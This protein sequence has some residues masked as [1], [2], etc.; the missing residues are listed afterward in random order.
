MV[1]EF[2]RQRGIAAYQVTLD[3]VKAYETV[4]HD[5][6]S[7]CALELGF[8]P[9]LLRFL[10][11]LYRGP[12]MIT[13]GAPVGKTVHATQTIVGGC[14]FADLLLRA[15]MLKVLAP[16]RAAHQGI[17][18]A[19]VADDVQLLGISER[20]MGMTF[21]EFGRRINTRKS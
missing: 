17:R 21:S 4:R 13:I 2:A 12:R 3:I 14:A 19:V 10:L 11:R 9:A 6:A 15:I 1:V 7:S 8:N 16:L 18:L 5:V 20:V